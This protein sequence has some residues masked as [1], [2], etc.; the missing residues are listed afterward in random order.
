MSHDG[1]WL[2]KSVEYVFYTQTSTR[3]YTQS[4]HSILHTCHF[5]TVTLNSLY[6]SP[7]NLPLRAIT[8]T[9]FE[10]VDYNALGFQ[11]WPCYIQLEFGNKSDQKWATAVTKIGAS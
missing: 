3:N 10:A 1:F 2:Y 7:T 9:S 4:I 6:Y 5:L 8:V 11:A